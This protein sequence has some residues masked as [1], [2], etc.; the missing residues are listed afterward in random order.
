MTSR[1]VNFLSTYTMTKKGRPVGS[2]KPEWY[3]GLIN[4]AGD[5]WCWRCKEY[6]PRS[7]FPTKLGRNECTSCRRL[8][9]YGLTK[10]TFAKLPGANGI[11]PLC[12]ENPARHIDHDHAC[13]PGRHSCG[14]CLRSV[15]C[16][17]CNHMVGRVEEAK[18][19]GRLDRI[20]RYVGV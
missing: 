11:C 9:R 14:K 16:A 4:E 3:V 5:H 8:R 18:R 10:K 12:L 20:L 6:L 15:L 2:M 7:D 19:V 17:S 13:C 1:V